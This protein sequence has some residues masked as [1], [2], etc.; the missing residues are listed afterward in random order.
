[1]EPGISECFNKLDMVGAAKD[2]RRFNYV[3]KVSDRGSILLFV[4]M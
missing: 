1:M 2:M 3:C 4:E